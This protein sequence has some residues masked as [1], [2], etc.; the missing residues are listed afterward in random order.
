MSSVENTPK[1]AFEKLLQ[2]ASK[3]NVKYS[4]SSENGE[5]SLSA[6]L[7][8]CLRQLLVSRK[9]PAKKLPCLICGKLFEMPTA[10]VDHSLI[11]LR[12]IQVSYP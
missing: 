12:E 10:F 4:K 3:D 6:C 2:S 7:P 8:P 9:T 11:H 1:W 5:K